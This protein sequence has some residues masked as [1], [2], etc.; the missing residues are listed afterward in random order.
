MVDKQKEE[1]VKYYRRR[2]GIIVRVLDNV[3]L[4]YLSKEYTWI[5]NQEWYVSMFVDGTDDYIEI[6]KEEVEKFLDEKLNSKK[7]TR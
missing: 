1:P 2:S 3:A 4:E 7:M 5:P 6:S